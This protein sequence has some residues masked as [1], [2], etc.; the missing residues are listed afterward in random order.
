[1]VLQQLWNWMEVK[2][3]GTMKHSCLRVT[4]GSSWISR[5]ESMLVGKLST[6]VFVHLRSMQI[7]RKVVFTN[8]Y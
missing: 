1:M 4:S 2:A 7:I 3:G 8:C 5:K 6:L